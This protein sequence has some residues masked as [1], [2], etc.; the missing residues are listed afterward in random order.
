MA[1]LL[2][3]RLADRGFIAAVAMLP[4]AAQALYRRGAVPRF[5]PCDVKL[6]HVHWLGREIPS[7]S[8]VAT[9]WLKLPSN[10][11]N[12]PNQH[13][14]HQAPMLG[15][16]I[17]G[18]KAAVQTNRAQP[19]P[20]SLLLWPRCECQDATKPYAILF[21]ELRMLAS[22]PYAVCAIITKAG[23]KALTVTGH[24]ISTAACQC[25]FR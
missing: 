7:S 22:Y 19:M 24:G 16:S 20:K 8:H 17:L 9:A 21:S 10:S 14:R 11:T 4:D 2:A 23:C 6:I 5:E 12:Q 25:H 18:A 15:V 1:S 3:F 13:Q